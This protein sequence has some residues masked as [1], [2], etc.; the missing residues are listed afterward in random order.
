MI[1]DWRVDGYRWYQNGSKAI[2]K[3]DPKIYFVIVLPS[4]NDKRFKRNAYFLLD[5]GQT[6]NVVL[7]QYIGD[8][9]I[10]VDFPHGNSKHNQNF[11]RT[12]P[13]TLAKLADT[14]DLPGNIY[15]NCVSTNDCLPEYH[16]ILKPRN[17]K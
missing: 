16:S 12:C 3:K 2:P 9:C 11:Y 17:T 1:G 8:E 4:G 15:K 7:L 10:A 6:A 13:S 14:N 5:A